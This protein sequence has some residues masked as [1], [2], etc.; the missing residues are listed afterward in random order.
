LREQDITVDLGTIP[1][2]SPAITDR[3]SNLMQS[4]ERNPSQDKELG[5]LACS[6]FQIK[7]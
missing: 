7:A 4:T 6:I 5:K 2:V 1:N 3:V